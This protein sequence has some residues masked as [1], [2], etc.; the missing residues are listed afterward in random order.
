MRK[1]QGLYHTHFEELNLFEREHF[2]LSFSSQQILHVSTVTKKAL[3]IGIHFD[4]SIVELC[5]H[6]VAGDRFRSLGSNIFY[7]SDRGRSRLFMIAGLL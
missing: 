4:R 6:M 1:R 5:F 3:D 7:P 2:Y